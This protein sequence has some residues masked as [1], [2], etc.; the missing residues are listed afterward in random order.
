MQIGKYTIGYDPADSRPGKEF[1]PDY[2]GLVI[3][4]GDTIKAVFVGDEADIIHEL[5]KEQS[6]KE[7]R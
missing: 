5:L 1:N 4:E 7:R 6:T 3:R 2:A